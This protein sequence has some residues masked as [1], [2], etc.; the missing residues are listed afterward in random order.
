[1]NPIIPAGSSTLRIIRLL[2]LAGAAVF[3]SP[4]RAGAYTSSDIVINGKSQL[5]TLEHVASG[6][7]HAFSFPPVAPPVSG[8][9]GALKVNYIRCYPKYAKENV[10][11]D[12]EAGGNAF[13]IQTIADC[14][15][16][17]MTNSVPPWGKDPK[18]PDWTAWRKCVVD[19]VNATKNLGTHPPL[20]DIWNEPDS[21]GFF[22][23]WLPAWS[24][25]GKA[26]LFFKTWVQAYD[27]IKSVDPNLEITGPSCQAYMGAPNSALNVGW[28]KDECIAAGRVPTYWDWHFGDTAIETNVN[29]AQSWGLNSGVLIL[30]HLEA[31]QGRRPGRVAFDM[32]QLE[33]AK[34]KFSTAARWPADTHCGNSF[35]DNKYTAKTGNWYL[36]NFY[37][38]MTGT[39]ISASAFAGEVPFRAVASLDDT[40]HTLSAVLGDCTTTGSNG[41]VTLKL[42]GMSAFSGSEVSATVTK[43]PYNGDFAAVSGPETISSG[44]YAPD[45]S[46]NFTISAFNWGRVEHA[47]LLQVSNVTY[48]SGTSVVLPAP[49]GLTATAVSGSQIN[50]S[51][52]PSQ[53]AIKY[54]VKRAT[55]TGPY[56][57]VSS[58]KTTQYNHLRLTASN[59]YYYVVSAVN[60]DGESPN[61]TQASATTP[62]GAPIAPTSL[63]A[64]GGPARVSL[65]WIAS[66]SATSYN[67]KRAN[68]SGGPYTTV[69][70]GVT[71]A[72]YIDAK[73]TNGTPSYYVISAVNSLGEGANSPEVSATPV[74]TPSPTGLMA[75]ATSSTHINLTWTA[76]EAAG[77]YNVKRAALNGGPFT[78]IATGVRATSY[79]DIGLPIATTYYYAV[80]A[81]NEAGES[82]NSAQV[83]AT[84]EHT[85]VIVDNAD[86]T[87]VRING[88]WSSTSLAGCYGRDALLSPRS[89]SA[90]VQFTPTI[91]LT[92]AYDVYARWSAY[93]NRDANTPVDVISASGTT[94]LAVNQKINGGTWNLLGSFTFK[95]GTTGSVLVRAEGVTGNVVADAVKFV[96]K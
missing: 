7:L 96:S 34:V 12:Q 21:Q 23:N 27:A 93:F 10:M 65:S 76:A 4:L 88:T 24:N 28:F 51:W 89:V 64:S 38:N 35:T 58:P 70:S 54:N 11:M 52:S 84:T 57:T 87:G 50:L 41:D 39:R 2:V 49:S 22:G 77:S 62:V 29:T 63:K 33:S 78:T 90:S 17:P 86:A 20:Y 56:M 71:A 80:S 69:A 73:L 53:G 74:A 1:M 15:G 55:A 32:A 92:G 42:Q 85:F 75:T 13:F 45:A 68:T 44:S 72:N 9:Y 37:G 3:L 14:W 48:A 95:A 81:A 43:V 5:G 31:F 47:Y 30:E 79:E 26:A 60:A 82:L 18:A 36:Y 25:A 66:W 67:I 46:G 83:S 40:T 6:Y 16:Y 61:S 8:S 94:T 59:S 91:P 19:T